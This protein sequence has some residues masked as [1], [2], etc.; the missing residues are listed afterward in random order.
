VRALSHRLGGLGV[1]VVVTND[2]RLFV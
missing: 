2:S 1:I